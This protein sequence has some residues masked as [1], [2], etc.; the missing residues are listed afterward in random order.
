MCN[1]VCADNGFPDGCDKAG[2][3]KALGLPGIGNNG[4]METTKVY[5]DNE[6]ENGD[7]Y[8][9]LGLYRE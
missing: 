5:W 6:K 9:M 7:Y 1:S 8:S 2:R 3:E 4:N